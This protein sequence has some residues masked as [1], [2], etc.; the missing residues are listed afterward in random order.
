[1]NVNPWV[2]LGVMIGGYALFA[3]LVWFGGKL[4]TKGKK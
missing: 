2:A 1:M 3:L 4:A